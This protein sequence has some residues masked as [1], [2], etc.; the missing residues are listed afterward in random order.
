MK[1][2]LLLLFL[3]PAC[4]YAQHNSSD[5]LVRTFDSLNSSLTRS[6]SILF[7]PFYKGDS[8]KRLSNGL[9][10]AHIYWEK[11][12]GYFNALKSML[13][14]HSELDVAA[15]Q[16][17]LFTEGHGKKLYSMLVKFKQLAVKAASNTAVK[18][19]VNEWL[20][21]SVPPYYKKRGK[22]WA[23]AYFEKVPVM[24]AITLLNKF[25]K[26]MSNCLFYLAKNDVP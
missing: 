4:V 15:T 6:N 22:T 14:K 9:G 23:Q 3:F 2:I 26:D 13:Q 1:K 18:N 16:K 25:Q 17:L 10:A 12:D 5:T 20:N 19:K 7:L 11:A 21:L 8:I 24:A